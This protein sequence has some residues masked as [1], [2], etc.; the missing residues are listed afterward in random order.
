MLVG[1][2]CRQLIHTNGIL[3]A[4]HYLIAN[5]ENTQRLLMEEIRVRFGLCY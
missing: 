2:G 4:V 3:L 5:V 1:V